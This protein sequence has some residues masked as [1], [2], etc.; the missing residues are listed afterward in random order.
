MF[1]DRRKF[2]TRETVENL[3]ISTRTK[4]HVYKIG[5]SF[6]KVKILNIFTSEAE[7][8]FKLKD[9][10]NSFQHLEI[11]RISQFVM[12]SRGIDYNNFIP[13]DDEI[14]SKLKVLQINFCFGRSTGE[15]AD[16]LKLLKV[17]P[18]L[19]NI[20]V[21]LP[22][23]FDSSIFEKLNKTNPKL[24]FFEISEMHFPHILTYNDKFFADLKDFTQRLFY[25]Q[26]RIFA[27]NIAQI[28]NTLEGIVNVVI[29]GYIMKNH[30]KLLYDRNIMEPFD[31]E[32]NIYRLKTKYP[33]IW[34]IA[35]VDDYHNCSEI[36]KK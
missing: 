19:E 27:P 17:L 31:Y 35:T 7:P 25:F 34:K 2:E 10:I 5:A 26:Y 1:W 12:T 21:D 23:K 28:V 22:F 3:K 13:D 18:N 11:L 36:S 30:K 14:Y 6:P 33:M 32:K 20:S 9:F 29:E 15:G 24:K 4:K 8:A 16:L